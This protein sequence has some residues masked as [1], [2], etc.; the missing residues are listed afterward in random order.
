MNRDAMVLYR[1]TR[2]R[3]QGSILLIFGIDLVE[4]K[5]E[6]LVIFLADVEIIVQLLE[7]FQL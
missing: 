7:E 3:S 2:V 6:L 4:F 5:F 1:K